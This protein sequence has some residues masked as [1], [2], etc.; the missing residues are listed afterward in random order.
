MSVSFEGG[1]I[2]IEGG[3]AVEDAETLLSL[4]QSHEAPVDLSHCASLHTAVFQVLLALRPAIT[5][6]P[7]DAFARD[8]LLPLLSSALP[9]RAPAG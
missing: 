4:L 1:V 7:P 9:E 8:H 6:V 5:G 2:R 3:A